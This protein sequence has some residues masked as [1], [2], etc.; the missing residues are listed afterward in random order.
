MEL[1]DDT[2][3]ILTDIKRTEA[4]KKREL[5]KTKIHDFVSSGYDDS[6]IDNL[7]DEDVYKLWDECVKVKKSTEAL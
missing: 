3:M 7:P 6:E 2:K 5:L 4:I 1:T